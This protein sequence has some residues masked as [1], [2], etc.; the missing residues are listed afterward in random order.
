MGGERGGSDV[1]EAP[2]TDG[3]PASYC[4]AVRRG[5]PDPHRTYH[6]HQYGFPLAGDAALFGRLLLE[7]NQAGLSWTTILRKQAAFERAYEGYDV[8]RIA[9]YGEADVARLLAD[10]GIVRNRLKVR[11]AITNAQRIVALRPE[12]GGFEGWLD[13]HH[14]LPLDA[15][16][17]RFKAT[18]TFVG[19]EIV[20]EFLVSTGYL[21][22]AHDADCPARARVLAARPP[23][24]R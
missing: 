4:E 2:P 5:L 18:F 12:Y 3:P 10:A 23:W 24:A 13:A 7:I 6:D 19:G 15:W 14:P 17:A 11:A 16:L 20:R 22:G 8:D 1:S 9:A 21:D